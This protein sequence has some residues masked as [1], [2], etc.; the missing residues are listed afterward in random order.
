MDGCGPV[1]VAQS[2]GSVTPPYKQYLTSIIP[3]DGN[4]M[5]NARL[6]MNSFSTSGIYCFVLQKKEEEIP[7]GY[8][9]E[10]KRYVVKAVV[11][12]IGGSADRASDLVEGSTLGALLQ[13]NAAYIV[14][15]GAEY[16][17]EKILAGAI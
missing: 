7:M 12:R 1:H 15:K 2:L 4:Y 14:F 16:W 3:F 13:N 17:A 8:G 11:R 5:N 6:S 10:F 9:E